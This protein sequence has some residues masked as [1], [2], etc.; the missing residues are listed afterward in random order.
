MAVDIGPR[1]GIDG[2]KQ[3]R[4]QLNNINQSIKTLGSE[5]KSVTAEFT[6]NGDKQEYVKKQ[7]ELL[8]KS[9]ADQKKKIAEL[10]KGVAASAEKFGESDTN[11]LKWKQALAEANATLANT[12]KQLKGLPGSLNDSANAMDDA[13]KKASA[14]GG[15]FKK[16]GVAIAGV[17]VAAGAAA[18]KLTKEVISSF[19][20]LEQNLGGSVAVFGD[21]ATEIQKVAESAYKQM[22]A[23]QSEYLATANKIGA[24]FQGAGL[25]QER[26]VELTTQAMQRAADMASVMGITTESALEAITG[27]AKGNYT[28][29]DNLGVAMNATALQAYAVDAGFEKAF[30]TMSQAEKAELAMKYFFDRTAQYAGNFEREASE[31][32]TGA[33]GMLKAA[34]STLIA[35]LGNS[36]ADIGALTKNVADAFAI[37]IKNVIPVIESMLSAMPQVLEALKPA[38]EQAKPI[39]LEAV[40]GLMNTAWGVISSL[41]GEKVLSV[42]SFITDNAKL[43]AGI[44]GTIGVALAGLKIVSLIGSIVAIANPV[45]IVVALISAV[46]AGIVLLWNNCEGFRNVVHAVV[47]AIVGFFQKAWETAKS[48]FESFQNIVKSVWDAVVSVFQAAWDGIKKIFDIPVVRDYFGAIW[49]TIEGIFSVVKAVLSGDF[50]GAWDAIKGVLSGWGQYFKSLWDTVKQIFSGVGQWFRDVGKQLLQGI[51]N[52]ISDKVAWLKSKIQGVV[53]TIKGWFTGKSGFDSHSPSRWAEGVAENIMEG[54]PL[55]FADGMRSVMRSANSV[56]GGIQGQMAQPIQTTQDAFGSVM[57]S[58]LNNLPSSGGG[59]YSFDIRVMLDESTQLARK[60]FTLSNEGA[61]QAG[62]NFVG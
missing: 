19:G 27:A 29:M 54:F 13:G 15:V 35:G 60:V 24:L 5:M 21:Y 18:V 58:T 2:E 37:V 55:G 3:F 48:L 38:L 8:T 57:A 20:E 26:S 23:S 59:S 16:V 17:A 61:R 10:E 56:I 4:N 62:M 1:I 28:M 51:W 12:E 33:F 43:I 22:G 25:T 32:V 6:K 39:I 31:T 41:L 11:T 44:I 50:Q 45:G 30:S 7:T 46:V 36:D 47:D 49:G 14:F 9:I 52:G 34:V 53:N 40:S 42:I